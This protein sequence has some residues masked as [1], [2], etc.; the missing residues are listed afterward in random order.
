[1]KNCVFSVSALLLCAGLGAGE[2]NDRRGDCAP[3]GHFS[4]FGYE[5]I[6]QLASWDGLEPTRIVYVDASAPLGGDGSTW[7]SAY[8]SL[9]DALN[10]ESFVNEVGEIRIAGG[11]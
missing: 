2:S 6:S 11:L 10:A 1:M 9:H 8:Q 7:A 5:E 4:S 3:A